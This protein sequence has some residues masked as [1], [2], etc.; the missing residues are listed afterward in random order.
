MKKQEPSYR[1]LKRSNSFLLR[2]LNKYTSLEV[3]H[4]FLRDELDRELERFRLMQ[5]YSKQA[6]SLET[7]DDFAEYTAEA[8]VK[9]FQTESSLLFFYDDHTRSFVPG[10]RF[11]VEIPD[12]PYSF[13]ELFRTNQETAVSEGAHFFDVSGD[14]PLWVEAGLCQVMYTFFFRGGE[15][16]GGI[17]AAGRS[18]KNKAF[19]D[20]FT[21]KL[22]APFAVYAQQ[23]T[24]V[25]NNLDFRIY[26]QKQV[27]ELSILHGA[28]TKITSILERDSL[29]ETAVRAI[30]DDLKFERAFLLMT[31]PQRGLLCRGHCAGGSEDDLRFIR[32]AEVPLHESGGLLAAAA[33]YGEP[34][35]GTGT[36][37]VLR[38]LRSEAAL[39]LP[40]AAGTDTLGVLAVDTTTPGSPFSN[41]ER[42]LLGAFA[43]QIAVSL[44]NI[45][46][47]ETITRTE[48]LSAIGEMAAGIAHEIRNPLSAIGTLIDIVESQTEGGDPLLFQGIKEESKRLENIVTRFLHFARP[49]MPERVPAAVNLILDEI[50]SI[51]KKEERYGEVRFIREFDTAIGTVSLDSDGMKQVFWNVILNGLQ[52]MEGEGVLTVRSFRVEGHIA[53]EIEDSGAGIP[54]EVEGK[55]FEPFFTLKDS[56]TGLGLP[57]ARKIVEAHG[58]SID[59]GSAAGGRTRVSVTLPV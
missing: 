52:A 50:M 48:R 28:G 46:L 32:S 41:R 29:A 15:Q 16:L 58:G 9:I 43:S 55:I 7:L 23:V 42:E 26:I 49:Y 6:I 35:S 18:C 11:A 30:V 56:G 4:A 3:R 36:D 45:S 8:I 38:R 1:E 24:S 51:L 12:R 22:T 27:E 57:I 10:A 14:M 59:I 2:E 31:D 13:D 5:E 47:L 39:V 17:I 53:V 40:L 21:G 25:L 20:E 37:P 34:V 54:S 33:L 44:Q 19:Y